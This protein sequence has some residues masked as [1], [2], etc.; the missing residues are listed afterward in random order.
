MVKPARKYRLRAGQRREQI[1]ASALPLFARSGFA[2]TGTRPIAAAAGIAEPILYRHFRS[3]SALFC[4]VLGLV[5]DRL[6]HVLGQVMTSAT[7][8]GARLHALARAL[9]QLLQSHEDELRVLCAA[10]ASHADAVQTTATRA[11]LTR[12]GTVIAKGLAGPGLQRSVDTRTAAFFL[13]EVG[14]GSALLR[15]VGVQAVLQPAF[16]DRIVAFLTRAL[17]PPAR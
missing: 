2:G 11:A 3:K 15:P 7:G 13:L 12:L 17:L 1:L 16:G 8:A 5:A 6:E 14:L 9:P 10:A 4:A